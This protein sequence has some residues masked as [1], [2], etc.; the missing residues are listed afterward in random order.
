MYAL[1]FILL[2]GISIALIVA[3]I[4]RR[5]KG[6]ILAG[7]LVGAGTLAFSWF[8]HFWGE[9]LWFDSLGF[10][11][12][13]WKAFWAQ[14]GMTTAGA[15]LGIL[16]LYG[17]L[18]SVAKENRFLAAFPIALGAFFGMTWGAS[19]W[20]KALM[21]MHRQTAGI[22]DPILDRDIGFYLFALP[23]YDAVQAVLL[24]WAGLSLLTALL[25]PMAASYR[26]SRDFNLFR[27]GSRWRPSQPDREGDQP[28]RN[29]REARLPALH[30]SGAAMFFTLSWGFWLDRFHLLNSGFGVVHGPGWTDV[31]IRLPAYALLAFAA[32]VIGLA[33]L[34]WP[35]QFSNREPG[36]V[37]KA[38]TSGPGLLGAGV[39]LFVAL[40]FACIVVVPSLFQWLRVQPNE[41]TMEQPYLV[42]NIRFTRQAFGL[43]KAEIREITSMDTLTREVAENNQ[44][45]LKNVRLWDPRALMAVYKQF[46]EIRLYYEFSDVD[47][48]RYLIDGEYRQVMVSPREMDPSLLPEQAQTFVNRR[49]KFTHGFGITLAPVN[50][51]TSE[52]LPNLL[53]RDIPPRSAYPSLEV[54]QPRIYFGELDAGYVVVNSRE[55]EFDYPNQDTDAFYRYE[56]PGGVLLSNLWRKFLYGW[57]FDGSR[58]LLSGYSTPQSRI[59]FRRNIGDRVS[60]IAPFLRL[61]SDPYIVLT[62]GRLVWIQDAY[63]VSGSYPYSEPFSSR[64]EIGDVGGAGAGA[65]TGSAAPRLHGV[66]YLR[67][68]VKAVVDAYTGAVDLYVFDAE[69]PVIRTW[70][71]IFPGLLKPRE[72]MPAD[73]IHHVRYPEDQLMAQALVNAKY[74]MTDPMV[75]YNQEDLWRRATEKYYDRV[76]PVDPYY[77]MWRPS[78]Q[79]KLEFVLIQPFTP[80]DRQVLVGWIAGMCDSAN[81]GRFLV[82]KF[83]KESRVIGPQQVETKIDQDPILSERMTL[84]DQHGSRVIRGN[85]L[86]IPIN[87]TLIYVEPIYIQADAAAYPELRLVA[88]MHMDDFS[89]GETFDLALER[90]LEKGRRE[91]AVPADGTP[92]LLASEDLIRDANRAFEE[93]L[94]AMGGKRF[95]ESS[96]ALQALQEA[97]QA[98]IDKSDPRPASKEP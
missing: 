1:F 2:A 77:I 86:A 85:V 79:E 83:P 47:I 82:Y 48:D 95:Q 46:Q 20:D 59:L 53:I 9:K 73:L 42:H 88:V 81:Y 72:A 28:P 21:F 3:G 90:L 7:I 22:R 65:L 76:I 62:E 32:T 60:A 49:F 14:A 98:L 38:W 45:I 12:R 33:I 10:S 5:G 8:M 94:R 97:L 54:N 96:R 57:K 87:N 16:I 68:S 78:E 30:A 29:L 55:P 23:W 36:S 61:D 24:G 67:N 39:G 63:S 71:K 43:E 6:R 18:R 37:S 74:H 89:Y 84:W 75:F 15:L 40:W 52:G 50:E 19:N 4:S 93:Y 27:N 64:E 70:D 11:A 13:F 51:F 41:I 58:F 26:N 34:V 17:L 31:N 35:L 80:K 91:P 92:S 44:G 56:G 25:Y 69:D 66:N